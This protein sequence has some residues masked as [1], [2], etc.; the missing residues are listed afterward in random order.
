MSET[1]RSKFMMIINRDHHIGRWKQEKEDS[2]RQI[3]CWRWGW[4]FSRPWW[5]NFY[6]N[7]YSTIPCLPLLH[8]LQLTQTEMFITLKIHQG[9]IKRCFSEPLYTNT[10]TPQPFIINDFIIKVKAKMM[11][12]FI[13]IQQNTI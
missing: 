6:K 2:L 8:N 12:V 9:N 13:K 7:L 10:H 3:L 5:E 11:S 1:C 4:T